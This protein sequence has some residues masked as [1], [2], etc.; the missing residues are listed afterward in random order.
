VRKV[1]GEQLVVDI[2][3]I[4]HSSG[5]VQNDRKSEYGF[6]VVRQSAV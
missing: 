5:G 2:R 4:K 3:V 6:R 1:V